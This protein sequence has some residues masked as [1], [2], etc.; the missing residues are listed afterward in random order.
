[1]L[2]PLLF[3][4]VALLLVPLGSLGWSSLREP[5]AAGGWTWEHYAR[6]FASASARLETRGCHWREDYPTAADEWR[7]HL[8]DG[9]DASGRLTQTFEEMP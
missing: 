7:G 2:L 5:G 9:I 3:V 6:F 4:A 1:M 8:L